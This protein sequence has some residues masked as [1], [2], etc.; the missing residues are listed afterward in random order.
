MWV[1]GKSNLSSR[2]CDNAYFDDIV[3]TI[4]VDFK[5][6]QTTT[7]ETPP[8]T[9]RFQVWDT[10]GQDRFL[11]LTTAY[12]RNCH[13]V[14]MCFDVTNRSSFEGLQAWYERLQ[15]QCT[16]MPPLILIACKLDLVE[17]NALR[18]EGTVLGSCRQVERSEADAWA[19]QHNCLCYLETSAR[20]NVNI[21]E[22]F[23]HLATY[24]ANNTSQVLGGA[25]HGRSGGNVVRLTSAEPR[26]KRRWRC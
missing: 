4:G 14:F 2:F 17:C 21:T 25:S 1:W 24:V 11:T 20:N 19:K 26:A 6:C 22:A 13:G 18:K 12:Y 8:R 16:V 23:Q 10:S 5:Y 3:P 9:V 15:S 7:L